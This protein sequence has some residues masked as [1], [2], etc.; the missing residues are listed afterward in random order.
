MENFS[1]KVDSKTPLNLC[2]LLA[3]G[4]LERDHAIWSGREA[5]SL[6]LQL[7]TVFLNTCL[8]S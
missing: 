1:D 6:V 7:I 4:I 3:V 5:I 8:Y 2:D